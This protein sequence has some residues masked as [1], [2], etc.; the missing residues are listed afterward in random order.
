MWSTCQTS[1]NTH[2]FQPAK[3]RRRQRVEI[4]TT[5][6]FP[7]KR[8]RPCEQTGVLWLHSRASRKY[9]ISQAGDSM[10]LVRSSEEDVYYRIDSMTVRRGRM[11]SKVYYEDMKM[12]MWDSMACNGRQGWGGGTLTVKSTEERKK[13]FREDWMGLNMSR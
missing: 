5:P 7:V 12:T 6:Y 2:P 10:A 11:V 9:V 8:N 1:I 3:A 13:V 4:I